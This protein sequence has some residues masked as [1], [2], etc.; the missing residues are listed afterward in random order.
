MANIHNIYILDHPMFSMNNINFLSYIKK[1]QNIIKDMEVKITVTSLSPEHLKDPEIEDFLKS[2]NIEIFP[3]LITGNKIYKGLHDIVNIYESNISEYN[4]H[5]RDMEMQQQMQQ[6]QMQMQMQKQQQM[7]M[8]Q[9]QQKQKQDFQNPD[10]DQDQDE[11][12][13]YIS[14]Q[15]QLKSKT[16]DDENPFGEMGNNSMMDTYR[17]MMTRRNTDKKNPFSSKTRTIEEKESEKEDES[18]NM[19]SI[20]YNQLQNG[21]N[22]MAP[23]ENIYSRSSTTS[24]QSSSNRQRQMNIMKNDMGNDMDDREDNIK[25]DVEEEVINIDPSKIEYDED[26]DPGDSILEKAYWSRNAE[27]K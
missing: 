6:Q 25:G 1:N 9:Q 2:K 16:D 7:Q 18:E 26:D 22:P 17:H 4:K 8:Q 13:S 10:Q 19:Q 24:N 23:K 14:Q 20:I 11:I 15:L 21:K 3:V 5:T 27:T 12:H